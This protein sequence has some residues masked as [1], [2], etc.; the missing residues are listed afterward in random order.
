MRELSDKR[1]P[2]PVSVKNSDEHMAQA[3]KVLAVII[4]REYLAKMRDKTS[5]ANVLIRK[6]Q[7]G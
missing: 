7:C 6:R 1:I 3:L 2:K 5:E 4:A